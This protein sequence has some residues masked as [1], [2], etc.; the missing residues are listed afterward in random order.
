MRVGK[1]KEP[2]RGESVGFNLLVLLLHPRWLTL[3]GVL[4]HRCHRTG[5]SCRAY[6]VEYL[7][8]LKRNNG[9]EFDH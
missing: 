2:G 8:D 5:V 1:L 3:P 7:A 6:K 9:N 4:A